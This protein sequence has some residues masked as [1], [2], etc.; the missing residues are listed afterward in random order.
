MHEKN[1]LLFNQFS[2]NMN[3]QNLANY[4]GFY[5]DFIQ[6]FLF[7]PI[8]T[9]GKFSAITNKYLIHSLFRKCTL[10]NIP[11]IQDEYHVT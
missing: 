1:I 3:S 5:T 4:Y 11:D 9:N 2:D 6:E 10:C 7:Y 8:L